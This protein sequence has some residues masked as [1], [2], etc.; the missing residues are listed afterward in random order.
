M[1]SKE[2]EKKTDSAATQMLQLQDFRQKTAELWGRMAREAEKL[3]LPL[4]LPLD[5]FAGLVKWTSDGEPFNRSRDSIQEA[6]GLYLGVCPY[7]WQ[8]F[9]CKLDERFKFRG[10]QIAECAA[11]LKEVLKEKGI[12]TGKE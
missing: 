9:T 8:I 10:D 11:K 7:E 6:V 1:S 5:S 12:V 3:D 4:P 2:E